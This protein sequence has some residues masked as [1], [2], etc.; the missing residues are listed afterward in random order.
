[1]ILL[2][3]IRKDAEAGR[4]GA[5]TRKALWVP[6]LR[7]KGG[8]FVKDSTR[9]EKDGRGEITNMVAKRV[10]PRLREFCWQSQAEVESKSRN[11]TH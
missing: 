10:D 7:R 9:E 4:K 8:N 6:F 3:R 2:S 5:R 1:M 11:K